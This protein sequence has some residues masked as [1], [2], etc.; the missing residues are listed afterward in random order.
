LKSDG[1]ALAV[2]RDDYGQLDV[3]GWSDIVQVAAG[4]LHTVGLK[5]DGTAVTVGRVISDSFVIPGWQLSSPVPT[6]IAPLTILSPTSGSPVTDSDPEKAVP[7]GIGPLASGGDS[8]MLQVGLNAFAEPVDLYFGIFIPDQNP[9]SICVLNPDLTF[10]N[11]QDGIIPWKTNVTGSTS[12]TLFGEIPISA[13]P[14]S[15]YYI[16]LA[17]T[18]AGKDFSSGYYLWSTQFEIGTEG[19]QAWWTIFTNPVT[20][21]DD[22]ACDFLKSKSK[23]WPIGFF[24]FR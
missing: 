15:T 13:L 21:N 24:N 5:S 17:A 22:C 4:G 9:L 7:I 23:R 19:A 12:E 6:P 14:A 1:T 3:A 10:Q 8:F 11:H 18:Q 16:Y 2:G 20:G